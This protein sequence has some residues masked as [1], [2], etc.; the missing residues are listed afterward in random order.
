[1]KAAEPLGRPVLHGQEEAEPLDEPGLPGKEALP[2]LR[3]RPY[4]D[5]IGSAVLIILAAMLVHNLF[6]NNRWNWH[7]IGS[8]LFNPLVLSGLRHTIQLAFMA[9]TTGLLLGFIVALCR[10]SRSRVL[11][12]VAFTYVG[13]IRAVPPLVLLLL[14][15]FAGA[16]FPT[17][18]IGIPFGPSFV[19]ASMNSLVTQLIAAWLGLTMFVGAHSG[20]IIRGSILSVPRGQ[21][22]AARAVGL[23]PT[24]TFVRVIAPQA[25]RVATPALA[26]E[27][28]SLFKNTSLVSVIGYLGTAGHG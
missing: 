12:G 10:L 25:I 8:Y 5:L 2:V 24:A 20:E 15:F 21:T 23:P 6:T 7:I 17:V 27:L 11:R 13:F 3:R 1:M 28:I 18:S 22:E 9:A 26:T 16:L 14:L 19:T 4:G